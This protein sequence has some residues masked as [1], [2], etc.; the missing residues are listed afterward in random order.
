MGSHHSDNHE[1]A[2][3]G[4]ENTKE[5]VA[6]RM[7]SQV[8]SMEIGKTKNIHIEEKHQCEICMRKFSQLRLSKCRG[9][10]ISSGLMN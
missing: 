6:Y 8:N 1:K 7:P 10:V 2:W 5:N 9:F 4:F 3:K